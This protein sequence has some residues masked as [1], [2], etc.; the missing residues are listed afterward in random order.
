MLGKM[1]VIYAFMSTNLDRLEFDHEYRNVLYKVLDA[2][3]YH[4]KIVCFDVSFPG[5]FY[6]Q[7]ICHAHYMTNSMMII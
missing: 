2:V 5:S 4:A 7:E 1:I 6:T 3:E